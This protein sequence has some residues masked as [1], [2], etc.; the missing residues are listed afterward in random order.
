MKRRSFLL[1]A[2]AVAAFGHEPPPVVPP[3]EQSSDDGPSLLH[4]CVD[5]P[6]LPCPACAKWTGDPLAIQSNGLRRSVRRRAS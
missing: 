5:R 4:E 6:E 2:A 1:G 3:L